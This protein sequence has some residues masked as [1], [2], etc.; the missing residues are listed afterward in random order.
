MLRSIALAG[1]TLIG[2]F[3]LMLAL[4]VLYFILEAKDQEN[5]RKETKKKYPDSCPGMVCGGPDFI[6]EVCMDCPYLRL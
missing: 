1:I 3:F 4:G 5:C 6:N 2:F